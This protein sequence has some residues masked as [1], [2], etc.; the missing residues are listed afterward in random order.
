MDFTLNAASRVFV[1]NDTKLKP[2]YQTTL[3]KTFR[4][5]A[6]RVNFRN[7]SKEVREGV[8]TWVQQLTRDKIKELI[9][10]GLFPYFLILLHRGSPWLT[11]NNF[12]S[13]HA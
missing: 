2:E 11:H 5:E 8:N 7:E 13:S 12:H 10:Q 3:E 4:S 1:S 9:P 6:T